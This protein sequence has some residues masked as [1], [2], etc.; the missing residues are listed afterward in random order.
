MF[1]YVVTASA[2]AICA[3]PRISMSSFVISPSLAFLA[4]RSL[5]A[6][7]DGASAPSGHIGLLSQS[8]TDYVDLRYALC[9]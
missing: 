9:A 5:A 4:S 3:A 8:Q 2:S 1:V 6:A 7:S